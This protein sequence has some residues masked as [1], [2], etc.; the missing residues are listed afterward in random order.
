MGKWWRW[1]IKLIY[2]TVPFNNKAIVRMQ[3]L[4]ITHTSTNFFFLLIWLISVYRVYRGEC[5]RH[6]ENVRYVKVHR[7]NPKHLYPKLNGHG[8]NSQRKVRSSCGSK[9]CT[10]F[11]CCY[12]YTAHARPSV[13]QPSQAH[14]DFIINRSTVTVNCNSILLDIHVPCKVFGT[15]RTTTALVR[16]LVV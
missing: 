5:A 7:Y 10:C 2:R 1:I 16:V 3:G 12:T 4:I 11:T 14:S 6:R 13:S 9:Y 15:L 8:D